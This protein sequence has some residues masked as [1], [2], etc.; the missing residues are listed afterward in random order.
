[1][2][3]WKKLAAEALGTFFLVFV[4]CGSAVISLKFPQPD[5]SNINWGIGFLGIGL[6]FGLTVMASAFAIGHISECHLNPAVTIGLATAGRFP[7]K[8]VASYIVAQTVGAILGAIVLFIIVS[9]A[10]KFT[11]EAYGQGRFASNGYAEHSPGGYSLASCAVTEI[12]L[13]FIFA[14]VIIGSTDRRAPAGFAPIAI[15]LALTALHYVGIPVT[16]MSVNPSRSTAT[17]LVLYVGTWFNIS[18][19]LQ[20]LW[21]FWVAPIIGGFVAGAVYRTLWPDPEATKTAS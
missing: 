4:G 1:M 2:A 12:V 19:A 6:A 8:D 20:E 14:L 10:E 9:G 21:L 13:T 11:V 15:G 5:N 7:N 17:A 3:L 16:N 18:W